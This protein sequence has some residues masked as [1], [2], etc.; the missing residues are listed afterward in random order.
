[1]KNKEYRSVLKEKLEQIQR[2]NKDISDLIDSLNC[3]DPYK[4]LFVIFLLNLRKNGISEGLYR[5]VE[6][7]IVDESNVQRTVGE[8]KCVFGSSMEER[9]VCTFDEMMTT[10]FEKNGVRFYQDALKYVISKFKD[11]NDT[12]NVIDNFLNYAVANNYDEIRYGIWDDAN[13]PNYYECTLY[14]YPLGK[15]FLETIEMEDEGGNKKEYFSPESL[16]IRKNL[17]GLKLGAFLL[18]KVMKDMDEQHPNEPLVSP[19]VMMSN[20]KA[21]KLYNSLGAD[22]YVDG[23]IVEDPINGMDHSIDENCLVVFMPDAIK[24]Y[25]NTVIDKPIRKI[26]NIKD[27]IENCER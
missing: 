21:L 27:D 20:V 18:Q 25:A 10:C 16:Y 22:I 11:G 26:N 12:G 6:R 14:G 1:M 2:D 4:N 17:Q 8:H 15:M 24:K 3:T 5:K 13:M 9:E 23:K 19:T 7:I